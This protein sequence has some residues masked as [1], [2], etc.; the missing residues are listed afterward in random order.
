[1]SFSVSIAHAG[2]VFTR[3]YRS[4]NLHHV[5]KTSITFLVIACLLWTSTP[6]AAQT[7]VSVGKQQR[8][9]VS[10]WLKAHN[11]PAS[12]LQSILGLENRAKPQEEQS[13][14]D[15]KVRNIRIFPGDVTVKVEQRVALSAAAYDGEENAV[16]GV[17]MTWSARDEDRKSVV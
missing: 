8:D 13:E 1:M 3:R 17:K 16:G 15:A 2:R 14:R 10:F 6:A 4:C 9:N 5:S 7:L 12:F 11:F